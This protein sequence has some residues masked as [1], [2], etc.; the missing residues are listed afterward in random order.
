MTIFPI[1]PIRACKDL[2]GLTNG[3]I[4]ADRLT[5]F[6]SPQGQADIRLLRTAGRSFAAMRAAAAKDG[7]ALNATSY[8]DSYRDLAT[9]ERIFRT[10][11]TT[12]PNG[13]HGR[14]WQGKLWYKKPGV[15]AAAVPGTSNH[16]WAQAIDFVTVAG[17]I[18]WMMAHAGAYGWSWEIQSEDWHLHYFAGDSLPPAVIAYEKGKADMDAAQDARLKAVEAK[19]NELHKAFFANDQDKGNSGNLAQRIDATYVKVRDTP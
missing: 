9:Q 11:Y 5:V 13:T 18:T 19:V 15:A 1:V 6:T 3:R 10:R 17:F 16:G 7:L 14:L 12:V 8:S 4:P 2:T